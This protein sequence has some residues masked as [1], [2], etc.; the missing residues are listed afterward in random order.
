MQGH[1][2]ESFEREVQKA[3]NCP[4]ALAVANGTAA[5]HLALM[6]CGVGE[7]DEVITVAN[8]FIATVEAISMV[9]ARPVFADVGSAGF[10][11]DP[12]DVERRITPRTKAIIVVHLYGEIADIAALSAIASRHNLKL[13]EDACQAHGATS[14]GGYAGTLADVGCL[15]FYP[16]KNLGTVGEGG[17]V[18]TH[19]PDMAAR[20]ASLRDHG[21]RGRHNHVEPGFNYR[22]SELQASALRVLLPSLSTW[23]VART[24]AADMY[25][26]GLRGT[27][28]AVPDKPFS[29]G[30]HVYHLFVI[31][32]QRRDELKAFLDSR[33]IGT[34][35][36]YP[37]PIHLQPAYSGTSYRVSLP[38]TECAV[39]E[40]LSL[41]MHPLI[42]DRE[43]AAVCTAVRDFGGSY[44]REKE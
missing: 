37:T 10:L 43:I 3:L 26:E 8:T 30:G 41:P 12:L 33:G 2:V 9:G 21:Q 35:I 5:L 15:S 19:N 4:H 38:N 14:D 29:V 13:I 32:S 20:I 34:A 42:T 44:S 36:H 25:R 28:V 31:R 1:E 6:A 11:M 22:L 39:S 7:G 27:S 24:R 18:L 16:T 23:N 40:I 17:M